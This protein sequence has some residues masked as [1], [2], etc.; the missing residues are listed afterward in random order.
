MATAGTRR[1]PSCRA[2]QYRYAIWGLVQGVHQLRHSGWLQ[3]SHHMYINGNPGGRI[4]WPDSAHAPSLTGEFPS[5]VDGSGPSLSFNS[6]TLT[7]D[8]PSMRFTW[9]G[10]PLEEDTLFD[11]GLLI[12]AA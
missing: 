10:I 8:Q 12:M 4:E 3:A 1:R 5:S 7:T 11:T 9:L 6:S 2:I